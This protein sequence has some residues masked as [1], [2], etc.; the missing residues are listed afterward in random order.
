M[1]KKLLFVDTNIWLDFYRAR[2]EAGLALL[3]HLDSVRDQI[4]MTFVVEMEFKKHRQDAILESFRELKAPAQVARPGLFSDAKAVKALQRNIK[5][6]ERKVSA[7][8][9]RLK[10]VFQ[11]PASHDP[12][13]RVSQRCFHRID[14]ITLNR[15]SEIKGFIRR[16]AF[17]RF[18]IGCPPR[19]KNDTSMGD[20]LNWEWI[21]YCAEKQRAEVHIVS[22]DSDYGA[23]FE[24]TAFINDHLLQEFKDR[25]SRKRKIQLHTRLSE[26]LKHFKIPVTPEE[27]KEESVLIG[28]K[29]TL[30]SSEELEA[31]FAYLEEQEKKGKAEANQP[32]QHNAGSRSSSGDLPG[33]ETPSS[34][35]P[36]G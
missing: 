25:V 17:R 18:L 30:F 15:D 9:K 10:L 24:D 11:K 26:A 22:R 21:V 8:K 27:E 28:S 33:S 35:G 6:A 13:Y 5:D 3:N 12:V 34:L 23:L 14:D 7:L 32:V 31:I 4:I 16:K 36:R 1:P 20:S 29:P 2:T 19:K